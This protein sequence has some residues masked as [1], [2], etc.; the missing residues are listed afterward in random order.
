MATYPASS[1][2]RRCAPRFPSVD[3]VFC[4]N[5]LNSASSTEDNRERTAR[6]SLPWTT[7]SSSGSSGM[8][9][10]QSPV[11]RLPVHEVETEPDVADQRADDQHGD[12]VIDCNKVRGHPADPPHQSDEELWT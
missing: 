11:R 2:F 8:T 12:E 7:G 9:H 6:R 3:P 10:L 4:R 5:Q 1:S